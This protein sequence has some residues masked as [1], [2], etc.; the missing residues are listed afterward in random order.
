MKTKNNPYR[1]KNKHNQPKTKNSALEII[2]YRSINNNTDGSWNNISNTGGTGGGSLVL[3]SIVALSVYVPFEWV[4]KATLLVS[5]YM[6]IM[7]PIP[8]YTRVI[9]IVSTLVVSK[10]NTWYQ[11][12]LMEN[13]KENAIG[14]VAIEEEEEPVIVEIVE[15]EDE[16]DD[17]NKKEK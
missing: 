9:S 15:G 13:E 11:S 6:F 12:I 8:P 2:P 14:G 10:L 3:A 5:V 1:E 16:N 4:A 17:N 7:D